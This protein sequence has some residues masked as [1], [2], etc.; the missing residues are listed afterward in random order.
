MNKDLHWCTRGFQPESQGFSP[1][2]SDE[3]S[4]DRRPQ[5]HDLL[6]QDTVVY[7]LFAFS[8]TNHKKTIMSMLKKMFLNP[9]EIKA[10]SHDLTNSLQELSVEFISKAFQFFLKIFFL[11]NRFVLFYL[12]VFV[13]FSSTVLVEKRTNYSL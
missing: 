3:C 13:L 12:F 10:V 7:F 8:Y 6:G 9:S 11:G 1:S 5:K 4:H 2:S